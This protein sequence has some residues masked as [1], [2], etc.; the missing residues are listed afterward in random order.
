[1][2]TI[3]KVRMR[4]L[5]RGGNILT[6]A[7]DWLKRSQL[8]SG[9]AGGIPY[10]GGA[11]SNVLRSYGYGRK[12]RLRRGKG[13]LSNLKRRAESKFANMVEGGIKRGFNVL[14]KHKV[15]SQRASQV[16]PMLG[17][18]LRK[19]GYGRPRMRVQPYY[20]TEQIAAPVF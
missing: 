9:I 14:K 3:R 6:K 16:S 17:S 2:P 8:L 10:I 15:F 1:M 19:K 11:A 7:R 18:Y 13:F 4:R 20:S 12:R 5:R